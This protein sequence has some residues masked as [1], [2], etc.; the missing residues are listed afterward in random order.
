MTIDEAKTFLDNLKV[1]IEEHPIVADWLVEIGDRN[2]EADTP[3][4]DMD[5][6]IVRSYGFK[7]ES[8]RQAKAKDEPQTDCPWE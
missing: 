4:T 8:Y 6:D 1:C 7:V 2:D 3:Q 5:E